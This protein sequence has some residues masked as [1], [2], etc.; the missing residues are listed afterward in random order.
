MARD[1]FERLDLNLLKTFLVLSQELN[2]RK[3]SQ[4]LFVSQ[5]AISQAL[6]KLRNHFDDDLFVKAPH[7]LE[8]TPFAIQLANSITPHLDGLSAALNQ[9]RTFVPEE[10]T[11]TIK[12]AVAPVVLGCLSGSLFQRFKQQAPNCVIELVG[13]SSDTF[14]QIHRDEVQL[15]VNLDVAIP[16]NIQTYKLAELTGKLIV[17]RDHPVTKKTVTA[18]DMQPYPIASVITPGWNDNFTH[19]ANIMRQEGAEPS[20]GFRSEFMMAVV[21]VVEM[22]DFF[23]PHSNLFPLQR[24]PNLRAL[25]VVVAGKP[26]T[27]GVHG[28]YHNKYRSSALLEWLCVQIQ[29]VIDQQISTSHH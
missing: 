21:D 2:M 11:G 25:D 15:G 19:A 28:Y 17:R 13:W 23:L 4:K 7:G 8:A 26:Y 20:V 9:S 18:Q 12:I 1:L 29:Q 10:L 27:H 24:Y 5:P 22:S 3:A 16:H 6:Q 14:N